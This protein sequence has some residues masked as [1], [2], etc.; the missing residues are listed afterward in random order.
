MKWID[1]NTQDPEGECLAVNERNDVLVGYISYNAIYKSWVCEGD[2]KL[3]DVT[4][5]IPVKELIKIKEL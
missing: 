4:H 5:F 3:F 1:I 2:M